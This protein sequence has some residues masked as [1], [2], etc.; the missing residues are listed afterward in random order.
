[1]TMIAIASAVV[2]AIS[3]II[4]AADAATV[5][6]RCFIGGRFLVLQMLYWR[7]EAY[8]T[9]QSRQIRSSHGDSVISKSLS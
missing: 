3:A 5:S 6:R 9:W 7:T 8:R 4:V 1:M 2:M